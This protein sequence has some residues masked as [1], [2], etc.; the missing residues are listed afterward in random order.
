GRSIPL[1][2]DGAAMVLSDATLVPRAGWTCLMNRLRILSLVLP[3]IVAGVVACDGVLDF[4]A[5]TIVPDGGTDAGA[6]HVK[7]DAA[8]SHD[9]G[10]AGTKPSHDARNDVTVPVDGGRHDATALPDAGNDAHHAVDAGH[11]A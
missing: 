7:K 10:D 8:S 2:P 9:A 5:F 1:T 4:G 11:E 6:P 3:V